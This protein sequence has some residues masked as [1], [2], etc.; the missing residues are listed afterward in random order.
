MSDRFNR[1]DATKNY[2]SPGGREQKGGGHP[3]PTLSARRWHSAVEGEVT[4]RRAHE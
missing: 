4:R 3:H 1:N 2:P